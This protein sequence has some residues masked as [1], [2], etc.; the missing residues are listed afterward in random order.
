MPRDAYTFLYVRQSIVHTFRFPSLVE[1]A[2]IPR[3]SISACFSA[4][5]P[6]FPFFHVL[7][8]V[9]LVPLASCLAH[10]TSRLAPLRSATRQ[11]INSPARLP[12][13]PPILSSSSSSSSAPSPVPSELSLAL[14]DRVHGAHR[15]NGSSVLSI[16]AILLA[17][18][19]DR[20]QREQYRDPRFSPISPLD[21]F[22]FRLPPIPNDRLG[23]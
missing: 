21:L 15:S 2:H 19:V 12:S 7:I 18:T 3:E 11:L 9:L 4:S 20:E 16:N 14:V 22:L 17:N 13:F 5:S 8:L 6:F 1:R 10:R 23:Y